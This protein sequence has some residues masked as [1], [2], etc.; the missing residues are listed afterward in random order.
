MLKA[1]NR[2]YEMTRVQQNSNDFC[3]LIKHFGRLLTRRNSEAAVDMAKKI[4]RNSESQ[5]NSISAS[6]TTERITNF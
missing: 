5:R 2:M 6:A 3:T 4:G 1:V